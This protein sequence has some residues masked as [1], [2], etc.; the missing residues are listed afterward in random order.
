M[1]KK[2]FFNWSSGK[3]S[4]LALH[5]LQNHEDYD[6][7]LLQT[8]VN[9][10]LERVTMHGLR[11]ELLLNQVDSIG[12]PFQKIL[13]PSL[14]DS[15]MNVYNELMAKH[16]E[17]LKASDF[18]HSAFGDIFLED[19]REYR[20]KELNKI[21]IEVVF[22]LWKKDTKALMEEFIAL[23][24]QSVVVCID[25]SKLDPSFLGRTLDEKFVADL[26]EGVDPCG[27]NGEFHTFC[28]AGPIFQYPIKFSKGEVVKK[29]YPTPGETNK[30]T[31]FYFMDLLPV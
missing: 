18:T 17:Q 1:P 7:S 14:Q 22:P 4:A 5:H 30:L 31:P 13:L 20:E 10:D 12:L 27:E 9:E 26:P 19:L 16:N 2:T 11:E 3:D 8:V 23:G 15:N 24:F 28:F 29:E 21:G 6:V 25:G